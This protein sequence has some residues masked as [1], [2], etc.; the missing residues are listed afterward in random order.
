MPE[1]A[2]LGDRGLEVEGPQ[3]LKAPFNA[4]LL[5]SVKMILKRGHD[6]FDVTGY[7]A[8]LAGCRQQGRPV[9]GER[10]ERLLARLAARASVAAISSA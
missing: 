2:E 6:G 5:A 4:S 1:G 9:I 8:Q 3:M 7:A 10:F